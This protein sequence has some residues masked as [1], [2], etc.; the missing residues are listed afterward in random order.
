LAEISLFGGP[1]D[2]SVE[3]LL[4]S[5]LVY[6]IK[7]KTPSTGTMRT[8]DRATTGKAAVPKPKSASIKG[9]MAAS[10]HHA[11]VQAPPSGS[12]QDS[13]SNSQ[14]GMLDELETEIDD[15]IFRLRDVGGL[16]EVEEQL[17]QARRLLVRHHG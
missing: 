7:S 15:L 6:L 16:S 14:D 13:S 2:G 1:R 10:A 11:A 12:I 9:K 8:G 17:R 4:R 3:T 5:T